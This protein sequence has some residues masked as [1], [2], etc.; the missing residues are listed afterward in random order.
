MM[1]LAIQRCLSSLE[2]RIK[3]W[4]LAGPQMTSQGMP[5]NCLRRHT[6]VRMRKRLAPPK[7][8]RA[9]DPNC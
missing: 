8:R 2:L 3:N 9:M 5:L 4:K 7:R 1:T 6:L